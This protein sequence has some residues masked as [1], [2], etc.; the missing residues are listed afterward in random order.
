[1]SYL[2]TLSNGKKFKFY[3]KSC[4]EIF[5]KCNGGVITQN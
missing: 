4:A 5:Q 1:M 2:L 3:V